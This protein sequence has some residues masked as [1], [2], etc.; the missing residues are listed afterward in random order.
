MN[1][2]MARQPPNL[3]EKSKNTKGKLLEKTK[4]PKSAGEFLFPSLDSIYR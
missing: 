4:R 2:A 1:Q 3:L